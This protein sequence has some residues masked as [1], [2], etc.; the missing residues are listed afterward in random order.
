MNLTSSINTMIGDITMYSFK[1]SAGV[2]CFEYSHNKVKGIITGSDLF[3]VIQE[4]QERHYIVDTIK[5]DSIKCSDSVDSD[6][7]ADSDNFMRTSNDNFTSIV[8]NNPVLPPIGY[9][10]W[11]EYYNIN[12]GTDS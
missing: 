3:D 11:Y 4:A 10:S 5:I 2:W 7:N 12:D 1:R 9:K 8:D 6:S